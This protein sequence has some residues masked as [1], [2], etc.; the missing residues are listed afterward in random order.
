VSQVTALP[1]LD[2]G[3]LDARLAADDGVFVARPDWLGSAHETGPLMRLWSHPLVVAIR[4]ERGAGIEARV[5]ARLVELELTVQKLRDYLLGLCNDQG[6]MLTLVTGH[7]LGIVEAARGRLIHRV[8]LQEGHL[9]R[10]QILAPTEWN[11]HPNGA[12]AQGLLG[13]PAGADPSQR[14]RLLVAA[15]DPCVATR[16]R[17]R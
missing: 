10:Y 9:S 16:I 12:L 6:S 8:E 3:A 13:A 5:A 4:R 7:G 1:D 15:L 14:A 17:V 2:S 11:F